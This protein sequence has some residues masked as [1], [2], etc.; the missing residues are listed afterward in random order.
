MGQKYKAGAIQDK[1]YITLKIYSSS[2]FN[3]RMRNEAGLEKNLPR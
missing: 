3:G 2:E 1:N